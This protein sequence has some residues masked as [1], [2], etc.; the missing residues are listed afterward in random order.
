M[1]SQRHTPKKKKRKKHTPQ[2][3]GNYRLSESITH[4]FNGNF[5]KAIKN[6]P[7]AGCGCVRS[8]AQQQNKLCYVYMNAMD[9]PIIIIVHLLYKQAAKMVVKCD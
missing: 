3:G 6:T 5:R 2:L 1:R 8:C 9:S 4:I 7:A